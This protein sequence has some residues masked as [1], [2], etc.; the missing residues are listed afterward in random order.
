MTI[1]LTDTAFWAA[2]LAIV[3]GV[4]VIVV[5]RLL[6]WLIGAYLIIIGVLGLLPYF[7]GGGGG[8]PSA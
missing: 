2:V 5:P 1:N 3:V 6:N 4:L 8:N 7:T